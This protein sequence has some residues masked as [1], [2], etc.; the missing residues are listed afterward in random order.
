MHCSLA[1]QISLTNFLSASHSQ[2]GTRCVD[3]AERRG[4]SCWQASPVGVRSE[5]D[6]INVSLICLSAGSLTSPSLHR[7]CYSRSNGDLT[8]LKP[9]CSAC[10]KALEKPRQARLDRLSLKEAMEVWNAELPSA[11]VLRAQPS[12][13]S[14]CKLHLVQCGR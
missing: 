5:K 3:E 13:D 2:D 14:L 6:F 11:A 12:I 9:A 8:S 4:V 10:A 7:G 1:L